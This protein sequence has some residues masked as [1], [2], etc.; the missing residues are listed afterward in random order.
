MRHIALILLLFSLEPVLLAANW[1]Q[2]RGRDGQGH[3]DADGVPLEW[4]ETKSVV[5]KTRIPGSGWSSPVVSGRQIWM[6]T[7]TEEGRSLRAVCVDRETGEL[8][9]NKEVFRPKDPGSHHKQNGFA[10][11][12]PVIEGDRVYVHF[13]PR[14][15]ACLDTRGK[16]LWTNTELEFAALQ[17]AASSPVLH[18]ELLILTCDGTDQQFVAAL[19]KYTGDV[20]WKT[21]RTHL[22]E[23]SRDHPIAGMSYSTPLVI[24]VDGIAQLVSTGADCVSAYNV[25]T[26]EEIWWFQY[27]GFSLVPRPSFG[28]GLVYVVGSIKLD[29]HAVYAIGPGKGQILDEDVVWSCSEGI[30][31]VPSPLLVGQELFVIH[32]LGVATCFDALTGKVHWKERLGGNYRAS[33]VEV[34]GRIYFCDQEGHTHVLAAGK[35]FNELATNTLDGTFLASP[36]VAGQAMFLRNDTWLYRIEESFK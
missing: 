5:W 30:P 11:P 19:D 22:L 12:T 7:A 10:S 8:L 23:A 34:H 21:P 6:T 29:R 16:P 32:D 20:K 36:A 31:H 33:P 13:G 14:G 25:Q 2:F 9:Y 26:G 1:P 24:E 35:E 15:T 27:E 4:S 18:N 3:S 17:G 28:N